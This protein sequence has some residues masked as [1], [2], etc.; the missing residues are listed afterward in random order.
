MGRVIFLA[1]IFANSLMTFSA[2][3]RS[4]GGI[5]AATS[6]TSVSAVDGSLRHRH[7]AASLLVCL[8]AALPD[9]CSII[10]Y[11]PD[12]GGLQLFKLVCGL[13]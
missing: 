9:H 12:K 4:I 11:R 5:P 6:A 3:C 7:T 13:C 10:H 8:L 2:R 1:C